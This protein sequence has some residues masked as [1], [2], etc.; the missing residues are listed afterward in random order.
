MFMLLLRGCLAPGQMSLQ[1][2]TVP[3]AAGA[4]KNLALPEKPRS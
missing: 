3:A 2:V 1:V 4:E